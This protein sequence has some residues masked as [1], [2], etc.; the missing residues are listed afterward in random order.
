M[1]RLQDPAYS[2]L[3]APVH[4]PLLP[5]LGAPVDW[6]DLAV[7]PH[8]PVVVTCA[9]LVHYHGGPSPHSVLHN[10]LTGTLDS[11]GLKFSKVSHVPSRIWASVWAA[12]LSGIK[13][14][15]QCLL[16]NSFSSFNPQTKC[17]HHWVTFPVPRQL[18]LRPRA[19]PH[20]TSILISGSITW[21]THEEPTLV[22]T[23]IEPK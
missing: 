22:S 17:H 8:V 4:W 16:T 20:P 12:P 6:K 7:G 10:P 14:S 1:S 18:V 21:I 13:L 3:P 23:Q 11:S 5:A 2:Q 9:L 19:S 15:S